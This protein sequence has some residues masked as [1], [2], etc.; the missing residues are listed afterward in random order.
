MKKCIDKLINNY[1]FINITD[2]KLN[3]SNKYIKVYLIDIYNY[4]Y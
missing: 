2:L 1:Y 3:L 4:Y